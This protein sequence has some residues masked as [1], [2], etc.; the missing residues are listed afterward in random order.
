MVS[1]TDSSITAG[2]DGIHRKGARGSIITTA[3]AQP[4]PN[5][6]THRTANTHGASILPGANSFLQPRDT[7]PVSDVLGGGGG[8]GNFNT[9]GQSLQ[10]PPT[11]CQPPGIGPRLSRQ[12]PDFC[13][14]LNA[15][16]PVSSSSVK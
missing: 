16:R 6:S 2:R 12:L 15:S 14:L 10:P 8:H 9:R 1:C 4:L 11:S 7:Q 3:A 5:H 13:K